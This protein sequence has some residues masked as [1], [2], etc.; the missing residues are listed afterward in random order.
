[1]KRLAA[2]LLIVPALSLAE[3]A[4]DP[5][6]SKPARR[7]AVK[8]IEATRT[9]E[10]ARARPAVS[11]A[12]AQD[13][14]RSEGMPKAIAQLRPLQGPSRGVIGTKSTIAVPASHVFFDEAKS[15]RFLELAGN[16]PQSGHYVF[17][18]D[19]LDWFA[20]FSFSPVGY[21]KDDEKVEPAKLLKM[22]KSGDAKA[23]EERK[24]LGLEALY[25]EGWK[26]EPHYDPATR[27]LEWGLLVKSESGRQV[28]N[29]TSRVLGRDGV[30]KV[31]LVA[32]VDSFDADTKAFKKAMAGFQY[33][34]GVSYADFRSGDKVAQYGLTA[35]IVGVGAATASKKGFWKLIFGGGVLL[36]AGIAKFFRRIVGRN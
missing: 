30:T 25:T 31:V 10:P 11:P 23:N 1:M 14:A 4:T 16:P 34:P 2:A 35:L 20:V 13:S 8:P 17:A 29:Y 18:P 27:R 22:I 3:V 5:A 28:V 12:D 32:D 36:L 21:V 15:R 19:S 7:P 6:D 24:K 9:G 33:N 26:V